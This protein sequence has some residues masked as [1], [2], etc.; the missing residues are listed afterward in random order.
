MDMQASPCVVGAIK[1]PSSN[2]FFIINKRMFSEDESGTKKR[3]DENGF[4]VA[5]DVPIA[6][7][8][9]QFYH[10]AELGD[11]SGSPHDEVPVFRDPDA[12]ND[13]HVVESFDGN[14]ITYDHPKDG[15]VHSENYSEYA[16]GTVSQ[17]YKKNDDLYAKKLTIF[18]K[19]AID[20]IWSK[21]MY[22]LSIGFKGTVEKASGTYKGQR[23]EFKEEVLHGNHLALC[24]QGKAGSRYAINS[25]LVNKNTKHKGDSPMAK[26]RNMRNDSKDEEVMNDSYHDDDRMENGCSSIGGDQPNRQVGEVA[27]RAHTAQKAAV[28]HKQMYNESEV[29]EGISKE[30]HAVKHLEKD[31]MMGNDADDDDNE[32]SEHKDKD[33]INSL[34][35]RIKKLTNILNSKNNT[36]AD[37]KVTLSNTEDELNDAMEL[38][39]DLRERIAARNLGNS[40]AV[41][42]RKSPVHPL[43]VD[44]NNT[45]AQAFNCT[46]SSFG[47]K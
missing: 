47:R 46:S 12:F 43:N 10:R 25:V 21:E 24:E 6:K 18:S 14:P 5:Y 16:I 30:K 44:F 35:L 36:I 31:H 13:E 19:E 15:Y 45:I 32:F 29:E 22:Q 20:K 11:Y 4:L 37:L 8:G 26:Q 34:N 17:P 33:L 2:K 40:M 39:R 38:A 28:S 7:T 41:P 3:I 42:D 1:K 27:H 9:I 23:Y